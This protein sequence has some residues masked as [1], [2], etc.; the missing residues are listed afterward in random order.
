M[1]GRRFNRSPSR[2]PRR[3]T[4]WAGTDEDGVTY[5]TLAA[6]AKL[7]ALVLTPT[8][9][10]AAGINA[11]FTIV[12]TRGLL[13]V[14]TD[15]TVATES[16]IGAIGIAIVNETAAAL[17]VT[18]IPGS[19]SEPSWDGWFVH[20]MFIETWRFLTSAGFESRDSIQIPIDSK[21]MRKVQSDETMIVV[22]EG[23]SQGAGMQ[24][25]VNIRSLLKLH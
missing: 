15:Q 6:G 1:A 22:I 10:Q 16:I 20:Q 23:G 5:T 24:V 3:A 12:R 8:S 2:L 25:A 18:A 13:S 7:L 17:G 21:A 19:M 4:Q 11:P 14:R 9:A